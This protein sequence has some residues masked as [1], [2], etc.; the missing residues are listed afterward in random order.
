[1]LSIILYIWSASVLVYNWDCKP[2]SSHPHN[3]GF[4][5]PETNNTFTSKLFNL[6][7]IRQPSVFRANYT[8]SSDPKYHILLT[9]LLSGQIE[10]NPGP[11][12]ANDSTV[13]SFPCGVCTEE[14]G[15]SRASICCDQCEVWFH[16]DCMGLGDSTLSRLDGSKVSWFCNKCDSPNYSLIM[17]NTGLSVSNRYDTL[18]TD[19]SDPQTPA[20]PTSPGLPLASSSPV[21]KPKTTRQAPIQK[22]LRAIIVN[23]QSVKNKKAQ[24]HALINGSAPD[25]VFGTESWLTPDISNSEIFPENYTVYRK[26]RP[27]GHGGVFIMIENKY[28]SSEPFD[29]KTEGELLWVQLNITGNKQLY[30]CCMYR[31]EHTKSEYL[32]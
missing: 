9:L 10:T 29:L 2:F 22:P 31:P 6:L 3:I 23:C 24:L 13:H 27:D 8:T 18:A 20:S 14:C 25:I 5:A 15:W 11:Q 21:P 19:T 4:C 28:I 1:M 26:D 12:G 17:F 32:D 30:L 7:T 16:Q